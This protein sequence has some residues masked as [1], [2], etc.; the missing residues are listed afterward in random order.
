MERTFT[1]A[2]GC[3]FKTSKER[4]IN[5]IEAMEDAGI[6]WYIYSGRGM[7]GRYCPS[8]NTSSGDGIYEDD[9]IIKA[10]ERGVKRLVKD[11]MGRDMVLYT[12]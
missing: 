1:D 4:E 6:P 10:G 8:A 2:E 3:E 9:I 11:N 12:G 5:F 7:F